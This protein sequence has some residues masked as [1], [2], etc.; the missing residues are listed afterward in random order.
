MILLL[1]GATGN[2]FAQKV[3]QP[4]NKGMKHGSWIETIKTDSA[5]I[6]EEGV[7]DHGNKTGK[8]KR[9]S[10]SA[11]Y[12]ISVTIDQYANGRKNGWSV[13]YDLDRTNLKD[14]LIALKTFYE[15]DSVYE[16]KS[17]GPP[18]PTDISFDRR[19]YMPDYRIY[20]KGDSLFALSYR[21]V[22]QTDSNKVY[23]KQCW[24]DLGTRRSLNI[25][26]VYSDFSLGSHYTCF[27]YREN[28]FMES[29]YESETDSYPFH[30][31]EVKYN[32]SDRISQKTHRYWLSD[33]RLH[34]YN[35]PVIIFDS[36]F[37]RGELYSYSADSTNSKQQHIF[38]AHYGSGK[39][40]K[41]R[42]GETD[43]SF[44]ESGVISAIRYDSSTHPHT[45]RYYRQNYS[46]GYARSIQ[47]QVDTTHIDT[48]CYESGALRLT[49]R[50]TSKSNYTYIYYHENGKIKTVET[51]SH[52]VY[53]KEDYDEN[54]KLIKPK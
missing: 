21:M 9:T 3:N 38:I 26:L 44:Y 31:Y 17:F 24:T 41:S 40:M 14:S 23:M 25:H 47:I 1:S 36:V 4:D 6:T 32:D 13:T 10:D 8:W 42:N 34:Y 33:P 15:N 53:R 43:T 16:V 7:Y 45:Y 35:T 37:Y 12:I 51:N 30:V 48:F 18:V 20:Y 29:Y 39:L 11:P 28:G 49:R 19:F 5:T 54:G 22:Y 27:R 2:C 52:G 46:N 50:Y